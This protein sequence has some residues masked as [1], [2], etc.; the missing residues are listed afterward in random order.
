MAFIRPNLDITELLEAG[1][2]FGHKTSRWCPKMAPY[3]HRNF[4]GVHIIDLTKTIPMME[5]AL[6]A[7]YNCV[8]DGGRV[9]FVGTKIQAHNSIKEAALRCGQYYVDHRWLGGTL[10]NWN[11]ISASLKKLRTIE[12]KV[13]SPEFAAYTKKEQLMFKRELDK[14]NKVLGG[15]R[16]MG[17]LPDMVL[18]ID[19]KK[20]DIAVKEANHLGIPIV[21]I[22][23][24]NVD[25]E[26]VTY[27]IPGNDDSLRSN[28][29]YCNLWSNAVLMGLNESLKGG[30]HESSSRGERRQG[31]RSQSDRSQG[32]RPQGDRSRGPRD[33]RLSEGRSFTQ[34][35]LS[36]EG[37]DNNLDKKQEN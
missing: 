7:I 24:T 10:T 28:K 5:K 32:H 9:L 14:Y 37:K 1:V 16:S 2:H 31:D 34:P 27:P 18:V 13:Q 25:P 12:E 36:P 20:E 11:T 33:R 15:I 19:L 29:F 6:H 17:G 21:G 23:D 35:S 26:T 3:I 22:V 8:K 30:H 4:N